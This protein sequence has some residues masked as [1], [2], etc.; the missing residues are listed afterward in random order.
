MPLPTRLCDTKQS[1]RSRPKH[2]SRPQRRCTSR[3][4]LKANHQ[5]ELTFRT[6]DSD[7][8][9]DALLSIPRLMKQTSSRRTLIGGDEKVGNGDNR[10]QQMVKRNSFTTPRRRSLTCGSK[11]KIAM[12][13]R[14]SLACESKDKMDEKT[15]T[16]SRMPRLVKQTSLTGARLSSRGPLIGDDDESGAKHSDRR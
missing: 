9:T 15:G 14:R 7:E 1:I 2:P 8:T 5:P 6:D 12:P 13:K 11:D 16:F 3:V 4:S 10:R